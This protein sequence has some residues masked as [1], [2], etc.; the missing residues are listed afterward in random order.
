LP[1]SDDGVLKKAGRK[2]AGAGALGLTVGAWTPRDEP[3]DALWK[4]LGLR[5]QYW[6]Q[7]ATTH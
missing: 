6:K 5:R 1:D 2:P 7:G 3:A 4:T